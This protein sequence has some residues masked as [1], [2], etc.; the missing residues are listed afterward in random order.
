MSM[1]VYVI[2][3]VCS[4]SDLQVAQMTNERQED[5]HKR[6]Q[7]CVCVC[8]ITRVFCTCLYTCI[9]TYEIQSKLFASILITLM[10]GTLCNPCMP[11]PK[12]LDCSLCEK[13]F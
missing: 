6:P 4:N 10:I 1:S 11:P 12:S 5:T 13:L 9:S 8:R 3:M 7:V 2:G